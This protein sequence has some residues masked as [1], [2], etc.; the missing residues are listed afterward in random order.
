MNEPSSI[1]AGYGAENGEDLSLGLGE[2]DLTT[3]HLSLAGIEKDVEA[4][5]DHEVLKAILDQGLD[6]REYGRRYEDE[7]RQAELASIED[8]IA[9]A[10]TLIALHTDIKE[11]DDI[12]QGVEAT[13]AHFQT[14]LGSISSEIRALQAESQS[15]NAKLRDRRALKESLEDFVGRVSLTP[16]L[17][18]GI[19]QSDVQSEEFLSALQTLGRKLASAARDPDLQ[20]TVALR[21]V[22]P[23]LEKLR[24]KAVVKSRDFLFAKI[25][26][27]RRPRTNVQIKQPVL[28][29]HKSLVAF[30][31]EHAPDIFGEVRA[32]YIDKVSAKVLD[33][34][35]NYWAVIDRL[36][37]KVLTEADTLG[38]AEAPSSGGDRALVLSHV[39]GPPL[40]L[41]AA[42][43]RG[44]RF[45]YEVLFRSV[46]K[47]L[48][49]TA[50]HEY[51][52]CAEFWGDAGVYAALFAPVLAFVESSLAAALA[53]LH[54]PI[55]LLLMVRLNRECG[56]AMA[57]R[58]NP[59]LDGFYDRINLLLWPRL[60]VLM[61]AQLA[62][63]KAMPVDPG[64]TAVPIPA[65]HLLAERYA[66][67]T[68]ALLLLQADLPEEPLE[69]NTERLR[70]AVMN[71][72]LSLSRLLPSKRAG[73][74]FL[75]L[76][77]GH[78]VGVLR[79]TAARGLPRTGSLS[80]QA[81]S[82]AAS[83]GGQGGAGANPALHR[84]S[85]SHGAV[86]ASQGLGASGA[87]LL[88]EIEEGLHRCTSIYV[89]DML[90]GALPELIAFVRRG[91]ALASGLPEGQALPGCGPPEAAPLAQAFA[92]SWKQKAEA[93]CREVTQDFG[94]THAARGVL[95]A[96]FTQL[97]MQYSRFLELMKKQG[98]AGLGVVRDAVT[99]PSVMYGLNALS[100]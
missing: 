43:A 9:E 58:G 63:V 51:L 46:N 1:P 4:L 41:H 88:K 40:V 97:L 92:G 5:A 20:G 24:I 16:D 11:C 81:M 22:A 12:L 80:Q 56:L 21:D 7:L 6:P 26:D 42:E 30:L 52:F 57:R 29:R 71:A 82:Q 72:L 94:S 8:Y 44:A 73:T 64:S 84:T 14:D 13:L 28:L 47:L 45:P 75:I 61:D 33:L 90:G 31:G 10:D 15:M 36:E 100:R 68:S 34:F 70:Y 17:I 39:E 77:F 27:F 95:Q 85:S 50:A 83:G 35:R 76:N 59:A 99:L 32:A 62:S 53:E 93:M 87:A 91:E 69:S 78:I 79:G 49:D 74:V 65:V 86:D 96:V 23:E 89:D 25:W 67:L 60:K 66:A 55:A 48:M 19:V 38:A 18:H 37:E 3:E 2:L 54:D 98:P